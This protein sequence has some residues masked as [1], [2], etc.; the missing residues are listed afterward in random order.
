MTTSGKLLR[1][2]GILEE[3]KRK[4]LLHVQLDVLSHNN[5]YNDN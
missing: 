3:D 2:L 4:L 1:M 5:I